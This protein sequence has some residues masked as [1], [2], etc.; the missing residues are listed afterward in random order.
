MASAVAAPIPRL[1]PVTTAIRPASQCPG[2]LADRGPDFGT[3]DSP[4]EL[5]VSIQTP[6][7]VEMPFGMVAARRAGEFGHPPDAIRGRLDVVGRDQE[8]GHAIGD[9]LAQSTPLEGDDRSRA[10]LRLG[11]GHAERL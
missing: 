2:S 9:H 1:P 5:L 6:F 3:D 8:S 4:V 7:Q 11:G 10:R